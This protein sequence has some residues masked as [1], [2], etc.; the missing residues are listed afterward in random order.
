MV[1]NQEV[2]ELTALPIIGAIGASIPVD[3]AAA[4]AAFEATCEV[5]FDAASVAFPI[6][7]SA[8]F[9]VVDF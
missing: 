7:L 6:T 9:E 4:V 2:A 3:A 1:V 5:A 8:A